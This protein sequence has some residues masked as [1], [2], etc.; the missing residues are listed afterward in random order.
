MCEIRFSLSNKDGKLEQMMKSV[1]AGVRTEVVKEALRYY[2]SHVR[3]EKVESMYIDST[4]LADFKSNAKPNMFTMD[5]VMKIIECRAVQPSVMM[6]Q[7][8][9]QHSIHQV[10]IQ[11][12]TT[13]K[14]EDIEPVIEFDCD[15]SEVLVNE[16][17]LDDV[18][19]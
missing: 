7:A 6:P 3:D 18:D 14:E 13:E 10:N 9:Q 5:D 12:E 15:N 17:M 4:D 16:D 11:S 8:I 19:F 2:L 1:N